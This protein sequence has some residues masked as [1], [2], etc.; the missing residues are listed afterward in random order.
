M[1]LDELGGGVWRVDPGFSSVTFSVRH[2]GER[3][4]RAG[5]RDVDGVLDAAAGTLELSVAL[6]SLDLNQPAIRTRLLS[7]EFLDAASYPDVRFVASRIDGEAGSRDVTVPGSLT[8]HGQTQTVRASG[9]IGVPGP[10]LLT[11]KEQVTLELGVTIDRREFGIDWQ[12]ELPGGGLTLSDEVTIEA[13]LE[14]ARDDG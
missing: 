5:F 11:G 3:D 9:R 4:Y 8:L 13:V 1:S 10:H 2:L 7:D 6:D 12:E 14:L